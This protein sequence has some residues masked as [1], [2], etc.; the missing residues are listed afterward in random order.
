MSKDPFRQEAE[1]LV[2]ILADYEAGK[3]LKYLTDFYKLILDNAWDYDAT[4]TLVFHNYTSYVDFAGNYSTHLTNDGFVDM[5]DYDIVVVEEQVATVIDALD[6]GDLT[7]DEIKGIGE[8][9]ATKWEPTKIKDRL[10]RLDE[11]L[12][13]SR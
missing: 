10:N 4:C 9:L 3:L 7:E 5:D 1:A 11:L 6:G 8:Q 13:K 2:R 12:K